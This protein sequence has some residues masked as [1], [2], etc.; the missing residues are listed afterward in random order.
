METGEK[1]IEIATYFSQAPLC[2]DPRNHCV[3]ILK[4]FEDDQDNRV[5]YIVMPLLRFMNDPAFEFVHD[6]VTCVDQLL[7]GL[8]FLHEYHRDVAHR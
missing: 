3:P 7:E 5:S 8:V 6:I 1:E 4:S 2:D